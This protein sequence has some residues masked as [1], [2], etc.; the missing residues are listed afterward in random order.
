MLYDIKKPIKIAETVFDIIYL[1]IVLFFAILLLSKDLSFTSPKWVLGLITLLLFL[2]D[3]S[4][5]IPRIGAMW[6]RESTLE[7]FL[8]YGK[9]AT[10]FTITLFYV[11]LW[12]IGK[13]LFEHSSSFVDTMTVVFL[14]LALLRIIFCILPQNKWKE[15]GASFKWGIIRNIPFI[16]MGILV[17]LQYS[18]GGAMSLTEISAYNPVYLW[19]PIVISFA[20]YIPVLLFA[21]KYPKVGMLMLPKSLAYVAIIFYGWLSLPN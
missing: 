18:I 8:G 1:S 10:S 6:G 4:H 19:I 5:L 15:D 20:F 13:I 12:Y 9:M 3:A 21:K 11:G 2:G 16:L 7:A 14:G 17:I